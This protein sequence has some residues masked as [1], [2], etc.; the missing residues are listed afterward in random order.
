MGKLAL[1]GTVGHHRIADR[2]SRAT[3][4]VRPSAVTVPAK[5][6]SVSER[7]SS[8]SYERA[9]LTSEG[10]LGHG[11][12]FRIT[13]TREPTHL[14]TKSAATMALS[15][16]IL[17]EVAKEIVRPGLRGMS[18]RVRLLWTAPE[19]LKQAEEARRDAQAQLRQANEQVSALTLHVQQGSALAHETSE[20]ARNALTIVLLTDLSDPAERRLLV[21]RL[22]ESLQPLLGTLANYF[23]EHFTL[24]AT[25]ACIKVLARKEQIEMLRDGGSSVYPPRSGRISSSDEPSVV[26]LVRDSSSAFR[27]SHIYPAGDCS[28]FQAL[29]SP[30][31]YVFSPDED[32]KELYDRHEYRNPT[33]EFWNYYRS[34]MVVPIRSARRSPP[35]HLVVGFLCLD[36]KEPK[37]FC[38]GF[39]RRSLVDNP[40]QFNVA[41]SVADGLFWPLLE[42]L[43]RVQNPSAPA[44]S[45]G[46][47]NLL[48]QPP[49]RI[50]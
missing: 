33:D 4:R 22:R 36:C 17:G 34:T 27:G 32:L 10:P 42:F 38:G 16:I 43:R 18:D 28:A 2:S 30:D 9:L 13:I 5:K 29:G 47:A 3:G 46:D 24:E 25:A 50:E 31:G 37:K 7:C 40:E 20:A 21:H 23:R 44:V 45:Y 8:S 1:V 12:T 6:T 15:E 48:D 19:Q 14:S 26:A 39:A 49:R 35:D 41:A 11:A